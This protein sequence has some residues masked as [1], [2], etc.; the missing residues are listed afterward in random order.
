M[1]CKALKP[2]LQKVQFDS[3]LENWHLQVV[4]FWCLQMEEN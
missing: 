1:E 4:S 3:F 2:N